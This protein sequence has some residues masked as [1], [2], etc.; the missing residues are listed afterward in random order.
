MQATFQVRN[1]VMVAPLFASYPGLHGVIAAGLQG[2]GTL[3]IDHP[4][5]P[6]GAVMTVGDFLLCGGVAGPS[7]KRLLRTAV[8]SEARTWIACGDAAWLEALCGVAPAVPQLRWAF[9]TEQPK[10]PSLRALLENNRE[11]SFVLVDKRW[12]DWCMDTAWARDFVSCFSGKEDYWR[13]GLGM[14]ALREGAPVA[15]AS[16]YLPYQGGMEI[17]VQTRDDCTGRGYATLV[18]ASLILEAHARGL[19][20]TWDAANPPSAHIA[21]K[22]GYRNCGAY[23]TMLVLPR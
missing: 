14:L 6:Q 17:Q 8:Q 3:W 2:R 23:P 9:S 5:H 10:D 19:Q 20:V 22:L 4:T 7:V 13:Y 21:E 16:S 12:F 15:G 1:R 11:L 18:A